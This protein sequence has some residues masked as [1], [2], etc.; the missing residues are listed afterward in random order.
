[1]KV[2]SIVECIKINSFTKNLAE[3]GNTI[4]IIGKKYTVRDIIRVDENICIR[5]EEIINPIFEYFNG[6]MECC[7]EIENFREIQF[8]PLIELEIKQALRA[9]NPDYTPAKLSPEEKEW[10]RDE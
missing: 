5:L 7:F 3:I 4:P 1:M 10:M 8:P 6:S 9:P 2:G